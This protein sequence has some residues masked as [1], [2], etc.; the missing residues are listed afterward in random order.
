MKEAE[1]MLKQMDVELTT[2]SSLDKK[3]YGGQFSA[4]K[5]KHEEFKSRF[6]K[7]KENYTYTKK[8]EEMILSS[9][10]EG[11]E[12]EGADNSQV[13]LLQKSFEKDIITEKSQEKL[14]RAK[15]SAIEIEGMSKNVIIDLSSQSQKL[16]LTGIKITGLN[17]S[18][19]T[20]N[21]I[22]TRM[23]SREH[24]NKAILGIF[25]FTL[26]TLFIFILYTRFN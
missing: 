13:Q 4:Y 25:S 16:N 10:R 26:V 7:I 3:R 15:R 21:S 8:M 14:E 22:M 17:Q 19:D 6:F 9:E 12:N 20:G 18:I 24:R 1:R 11:K 5:K 2:N 23:M